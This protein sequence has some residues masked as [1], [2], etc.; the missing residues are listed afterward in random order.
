MLIKYSSSFCQVQR[1]YFGVCAWAWHYLSLPSFMSSCSCNAKGWGAWITYKCNHTSKAFAVEHGAENCALILLS[2]PQTNIH[3]YIQHVATEYFYG[4]I[5]LLLKSFV[6]G[7][8][9][10][11]RG[12]HHPSSRSA[13]GRTVRFHAYGTSVCDMS[14]KRHT[15]TYLPKWT[16]LRP[17]RVRACPRS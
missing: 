1:K 5:N 11:I 12:A 3:C 15:S 8:E 4:A 9:H 14:Q 13:C 10:P 17:S 7:F 2:P 6:K 16:S